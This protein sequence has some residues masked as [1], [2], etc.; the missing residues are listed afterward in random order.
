M[1]LPDIQA[2]EVASAHWVPL[3]CCEH[4]P[5]SCILSLLM[6]VLHPPVLAPHVQWGDVCIDITS[7]IS[8]R[9]KAIRK[10]LSILTGN[11][12]FKCILLP[13]E[14]VGTQELNTGHPL[15]PVSLA[16]ERPPLSLWGL[17]L[18]MS[19]DLLSHMQLPQTTD[20]KTISA[21]KLYGN[22][23]QL[24]DLSVPPTPHTL[25]P[26]LFAPSMTSIFPTFSYPDIN[27]FIWIFGSRYRHLVK[28]WNDRLSY[29]NS[30]GVPMT[31]L[32]E[33]GPSS[34]NGHGGGA[35]SRQQSAGRV[36]FSAM[37]LNQFYAAVRKALI[38]AIIT[39]AILAFGT[40]SAATWYL[41]K[42][43]KARR[44]RLALVA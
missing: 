17:T 40:L 36:N 31:P 34:H 30:R 37:A 33:T 44:R 19:L 3:T 14:P 38:V 23:S 10:I 12:H 18:G 22:S 20:V 24:Y 41:V 4:I 13:N 28:R 15:D 25:Y 21:D 9:S 1:P 39:R 29:N 35:P 2:S 27:F 16:S 43:I 42:Y 8:P 7:R 6:V 26:T 32:S 5:R 11:M